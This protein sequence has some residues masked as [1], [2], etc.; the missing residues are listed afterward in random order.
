MKDKVQVI[1][2]DGPSGVGKGTLSCLL[3]QHLGW[4]FLD[5]GALYRVLALAAE[6]HGVDLANEDA[7]VV[8][9]GYLDVSFVTDT[10]GHQQVILEGERVTDSLRSEQCA[11]SASK[12]AA[13]PRVREALLRRQRAFRQEP[14]LVADGR[15]M[16]TIVFTDAI[17][18]IFLTAS[19]EVR[20]LRR[21]RQL[22]E[23]GQDASL[24]D[25]VIGINAR[26]QRDSQRSVAPLRPAEDAWLLDSSELSAQEVFERVL[27]KVQTYLA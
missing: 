4:H 5:S 25:L 6:H 9:A 7:L 22:Q 2:V 23:Q 21:Q 8:L 18:K 1:T 16:G 13:L 10:Q 19:P 17:L 15:D 20:A 11:A 12:V 14:G 26:D 24:S 27:A 3:A